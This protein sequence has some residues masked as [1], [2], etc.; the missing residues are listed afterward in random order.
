MS[1]YFFK[2]QL[3][4]LLNVR[5]AKIVL[6]FIV[7]GRISEGL[8]VHVQRRQEHAVSILDQIKKT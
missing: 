8:K 6:A 1:L 4:N 5:D 3:K 7:M 2:H